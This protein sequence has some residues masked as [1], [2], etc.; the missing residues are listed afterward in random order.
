M[1]GI[2]VFPAAVKLTDGPTYSPAKV[3]TAG[4]IVRVW[5]LVGREPTLVAS[6]EAATLQPGT[7][8]VLASS[9]AV[10]IVRRSGCGCSHPLKRFRPPRSS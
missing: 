3:D 7:G 5:A 8:K 9:D 1:V 2:N 6:F 4:D 10:E